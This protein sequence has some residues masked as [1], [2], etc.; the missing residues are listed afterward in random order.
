[1]LKGDL[2]DLYGLVLAHLKLPLFHCGLEPF[3]KGG[4]V[5][6]QPRLPEVGPYHH[7][8]CVAYPG[9]LLGHVDIFLY[10]PRMERMHK[11]CE[12]NKAEGCN[13]SIHGSPRLLNNVEQF[14]FKDER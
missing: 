13:V 11:E 7:S 6:F 8:E 5:H 1:L 9:F 4:I 12:G 3:G 10:R 2:H 14:Y